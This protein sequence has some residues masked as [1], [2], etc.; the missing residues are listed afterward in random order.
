RGASYMRPSRR[1]RSRTSH[2][3]VGAALLLAAGR[4]RAAQTTATISMAPPPA[5]VRFHGPPVV[6]TRPGAAF[7]YTLPATGTKPITF[8]ATR[9]PAGRPLNAGSGQT[10]G[11]VPAPGQ[12]PIAVHASNAAG[13]DD[14]TLTLSVGT[15]L[16][17]TP[18]MG[19][20]SYDSYGSSVTEAEVMAEA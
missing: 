3:V 19:W 5:A 11:S 13:S 8:S 18:P 17:P 7:L 12:Y 4:G 10:P 1:R 20:N 2:L 9:R 15:S 16:S 14:R 6:A